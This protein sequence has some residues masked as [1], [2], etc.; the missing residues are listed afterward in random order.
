MLVTMVTIAALMTGAVA[1]T[2][3][4]MSSTRSSDMTRSG[5][6][7][8]FCAEAGL[9]AARSLVASNQASWSDALEEAAAAAP[10]APREPAFF[11]SLDHDLDD[12]GQDD[13][14]VYLRDNHD[15]LPPNTDNPSVDNDL[16]VYIVSRCIKYPETSREVIELVEAAVNG[17]G[18]RSQVGSSWPCPDFV[19]TG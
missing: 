13:I 4:Q 8:Q 17:A 12:D 15:E 18:Y 6:S 11:S 10:N 9:T 7:A 16:R 19:D 5:I 1:L 14:V 2:Q 3:I